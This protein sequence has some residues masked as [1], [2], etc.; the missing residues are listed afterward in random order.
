MITHDYG[1]NMTLIQS[2]VLVIAKGF[3]HPHELSEQLQVDLT[4][5][6]TATNLAEKTT[7]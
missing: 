3:Y 6:N 1:F 2:S 4:I 5:A 7:S